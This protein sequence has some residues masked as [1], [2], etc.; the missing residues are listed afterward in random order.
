MSRAASPTDDFLIV[1]RIRRPHGVRGDCTV[2]VDTDRPDAVFRKGRVLHLGD[3]AGD[4]MGR[5]LIVESFRPTPAGAILRLTDV[6]SREAAEELRGHTLLIRSIEAQPPDRN[7][8]H[9]RDLIGMVGREDEREVGT[10]ED[11]LELPTGEILVLRSPLG[12]EILIPFVRD[13]VVGLD[14]PNRELKLKLPPGLLDL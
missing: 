4:P 12:K 6:G 10:V 7:E 1:A 9:Y 11:I 8:V 13:I 2:A 14:P 3:E 5:Q